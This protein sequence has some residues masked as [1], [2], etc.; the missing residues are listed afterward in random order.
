MA[1]GERFC[2]LKT[3]SITDLL[4]SCL[5]IGFSPHSKQVFERCIRVIQHTFNVV[6]AHES[7]PNLEEP[8]RDF[9]IVALDLMAG[10]V[11]GLGGSAESLVEFYKT[12]IMQCLHI[13]LNVPI[14][15]FLSLSSFNLKMNWKY[16]I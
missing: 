16:G 5:G 14:K 1:L 3:L 13:T 12:E 4:L 8:D 2:L 6:K 7:N 10:V 11:Q 9:Y 15:F